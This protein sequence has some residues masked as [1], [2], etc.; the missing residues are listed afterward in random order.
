MLLPR[1]TPFLGELALLLSFVAAQSSDDLSW[2]PFDRRQFDNNTILD[3]KGDV[4]LFWKTGD[5]FSTY[6][7]ASRSSGYLA[8]GFS[9]TGAMTG[10]DMAVG[11]KD[12]KGDFVFENRHAPGFVF[13]VVS[14]DQEKNMRYVEGHQTNGVTGFVFEKQ[15]EAACL[16][17]QANVHVNSWQWFIYAFS[18]DN[19]F[20][21]HGP[22]HNGKSYVKLGDGKTV[23]VNEIRD[24]ADSKNF[25]VIQPEVTIP[26]AE[27]T[28]CYSL[29]KLPAGKRNFLLGERPAKSSPLL[30]HLVLYGCYGLPDDVKDMVG[31]EPNCDWETFS[32]PCNSFVTEWAPGMSGRTF[33]H[34]YGKPFGSDL[35]EYA[36]LETHY[37]NPELLEDQKDSAAYTFLYTDQQVENEIGTLTLG[38]L[39]V[40]GWFLEP[41]K[42]LVPHSTVC[43]PECTGHWPSEGITAVSVFHHMH[44]RGRNARVQIIRDNKEIAPLSSLHNF[45]YGYQ[46]SKNLDQV[47]LLPGDKF[48]T[49][50]EY[51]TSN[52]TKPVA[53]GLS[54]KEEMCF[55]WVDYYPANKIL[56]CT[57]INLGEAP[58]NPINGSAAYCM[59]A[60][61]ETPDLYKSPSLTSS[62][63]TLPTTGDVCP[64]SDTSGNSTS[65]TDGGSAVLRTCPETDVCYSINVPEQSASSGS[66]DIYFQLSA[67]TT[68]QWVALA[69][70]TAMDNANMFIM[71]SS[72]DGTNV[73]LSARNTSGHTMPIHNDATDVSLMDGSGIA[74][75]RM[76]ANVRCGNCN[77]WGTG[78]MSLQ[79][80]SSDWLY[81]FRQGSPIDSDDT[82]AA[83]SQHD[84]KGTFQ[85]DLSRATGGSAPNPFTAS[86]S[87]TTNSS[88]SASE[89]DRMSTQTQS[90]YASAH[91]ALASLAFVAVFPIGALL[92]RLSHLNNLP[93]IHGTIQIFG[94]ILFLAAAGLGIYIATASS[95]LNEP[96]AVIGILLLAVLSFMP[97][98]GALHHKVYK[99]LQKR[100]LWSYV[101]IF[102]G[103]VAIILGIVNGG[104]GLHLAEAR[105]SYVVAYGI[106]A[107]GMG[108]FYLGVIFHEMK[109]G[110][111]AKVGAGGLGEAKGRGTEEGGRDTS[112]EHSVT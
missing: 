74:N 109:R 36:M 86:A 85:W 94:Y 37:N 107:G 19:T 88:S 4:R 79:D 6:G 1:F 12:Q 40:T 9:E 90:Q 39:Q 65:G 7:I 59:E 61:A 15:N 53:G 47:K 34:G 98:L 95:R 77:T 41:G 112:E 100:T 64:I 50:C 30:H 38:D 81:A 21:Q 13:P 55:A 11:Y 17:D 14:Q 87:T 49:T 84:N 82:N 57:Q 108:G 5:N 58:E 28:Y 80:S 103:R 24:V 104:L 110:R 45:E 91:G 68:Y 56:A 18:Q 78:S 3:T 99:R 89:W 44:F 70:G 43:T 105:T 35:Y 102:T 73:T 27:T 46:Y 93:W 54:S 42:E 71:H 52:D 16:Q 29:H 72:A 48:I 63:Q 67:P 33:E 97:F 96:H 32:N 23:S 22:G 75:S 92:V 26:T 10:A 76:T 25:T 20:A 101:H 62:F 60:S 106:L 111:K 8:L 66:G 31:K 83:I 2:I 51:D 69:Q